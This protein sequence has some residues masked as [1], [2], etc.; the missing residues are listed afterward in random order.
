MRDLL[1]ISKSIFWGSIIFL[2]AMVFIN[3]LQGYPRSI[4]LVEPIFNFVLTSGIRFLAR[5]FYESKLGAS[6]KVIKNAVIAGAGKA[7][8]LILNEI[9]TNRKWELES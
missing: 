6:S 8:V 3:R 4:L 7:G 5:F 9:R 1:I 2:V